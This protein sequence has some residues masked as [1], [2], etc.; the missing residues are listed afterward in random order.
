[1]LESDMIQT[2]P[3]PG[4][5]KQHDNAEGTES[6]KVLT[7]DTAFPRRFD[8]NRVLSQREKPRADDQ[9]SGRDAKADEQAAE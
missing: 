1:M 3:Y 9:A 7:S 2:K 8:I 6:E 5:D 4:S